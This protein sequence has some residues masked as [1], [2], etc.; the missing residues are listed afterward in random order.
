VE[1]Q[2]NENL[3]LSSDTDVRK[4]A[5]IPWSGSCSTR[6]LIL[7]FTFGNDVG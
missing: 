3:R 4:S 7:S 5:S 6:H 2:S 1:N